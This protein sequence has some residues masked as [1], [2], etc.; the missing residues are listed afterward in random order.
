[1][2]DESEA[3]QVVGVLNAI[4]RAWLEDHV[5][6][7]GSMLH[8]DI[9]MVLPGF[10]GRSSGRGAFLDGFR[11]FRK[12]AST[13]KFNVRDFQVDITGDAAVATYCFEMEYDRVDTQWRATGRDLWVLRKQRGKWRATWR[14]MLDMNENAIT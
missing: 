13:I 10:G 14:T 6:D 1:M 11:D 5:D 7:M 8:P 12:S 9:V 3:T 4:N 2:V